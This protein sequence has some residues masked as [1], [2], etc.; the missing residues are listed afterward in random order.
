[1]EY[2]WHRRAGASTGE[3]GNDQ[4][5]QEASTGGR[6]DGGSWEVTHGVFVASMGGRLDGGS[7]EDTH[8]AFLRSMGGRL[9][10]GSWE[11]THAVFLAS[12]AGRLDGGSWEM[13]K[14]TLWDRREGASTGEAGKLPMEY[15]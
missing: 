4:G 12:T 5:G 14:G 8:G 10:G 15:L 2:F 7:W 13:T 6:L 1:M 3:L 11:I 9:D